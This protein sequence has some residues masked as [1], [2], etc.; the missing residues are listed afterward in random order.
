MYVGGRGDYRGI[1]VHGAWSNYHIYQYFIAFEC[2]IY[3]V[4][5]YCNSLRGTR[6][7]NKPLTKQNLKFELQPGHKSAKRKVLNNIHL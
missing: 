1:F 6:T 2:L 4:F 3:K 7:T 5:M